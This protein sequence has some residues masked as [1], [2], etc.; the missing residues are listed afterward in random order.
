MCEQIKTEFPVHLNRNIRVIAICHRLDYLTSVAR[1]KAKTFQALATQYAKRSLFTAMNPSKTNL[2]SSI[3]NVAKEK[4]YFF[5]SLHQ[6]SSRENY[7]MHKSEKP[8]ILN[9]VGQIC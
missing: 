6:I 4:Y 5:G 1:S 3:K 2:Q 8:K 9:E 7:E